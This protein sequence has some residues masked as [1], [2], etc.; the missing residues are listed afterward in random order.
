MPRI[1]LDN[2]PQEQKDAYDRWAKKQAVR[3]KVT[4]RIHMRVG[5][6]EVKITYFDDEPIVQHRRNFWTGEGHTIGYSDKIAEELREAGV[7]FDSEAEK[8]PLL[9]KGVLV[10]D[11]GDQV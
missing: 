10:T 7:I 9:S 11:S 2:V 4:G 5:M 8:V 6:E 3:G 1:E